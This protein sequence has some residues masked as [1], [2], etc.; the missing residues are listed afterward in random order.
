MKVGKSI[1]IISGVIISLL[2]L[3]GICVFFKDLIFTAIGDAY[4]STID[5]TD[6]IDIYSS[7]NIQSIMVVMKRKCFLMSMPLLMSIKMRNFTTK[8]V[9]K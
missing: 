9:K 6:D 8:T 3:L 5:E 4:N 2:A 1:L 7:K